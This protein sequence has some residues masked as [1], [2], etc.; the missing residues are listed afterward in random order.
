LNAPV[1]EF[2]QTRAHDVIGSACGYLIIAARRS[3]G[4]TETG[5]GLR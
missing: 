2:Q 1:E 3:K 5:L 4:V